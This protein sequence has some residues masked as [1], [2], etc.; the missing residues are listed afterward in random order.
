MSEGLLNSARL[1]LPYIAGGQAQKHVTHNEA[2]QKLDTLVHLKLESRAVAAPPAASEGQTWLVAAVAAGE[3]VGRE[4]ELATWLGGSWRF[5][6]APIGALAYVEDENVVIAKTGSGWVGVRD[7][8][9]HGDGFLASS[10]EL[11]AKTFSVTSDLEVGPLS[12]ASVVTALT[13]PARAIVLGV[14]ARTVSAVTGA[15]PGSV[16]IGVIGP[17]AFYADTPV[18]LSANGGAFTGG[19]VRLSAYY[20]KFEAPEAP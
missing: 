18:I 14:A 20:L 6:S 12:G 5:A 15:A 9:P 13:I 19:E 8:G 3:W 2:L 11:G 10:G 4:G 17:T 7:L 16:N 1:E